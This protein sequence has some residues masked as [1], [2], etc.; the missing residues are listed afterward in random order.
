MKT[1]DDGRKWL[2]LAIVFA[3][4]VAAWMFRYEQINSSTHKN[5]LTG[6]VCRVWESCW[7]SNGGY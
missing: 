6:A 1:L 2:A 4:V 7:L 3:V 5:R